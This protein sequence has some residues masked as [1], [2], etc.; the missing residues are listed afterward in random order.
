MNELFDFKPLKEAYD[1]LAPDG[2]EIR[3]LVEFDGGGLAH[4]T[5][6]SKS[7]STPIQHRTVTELWYCLCGM[8]EIWQ[9]LD[10]E[11]QEVK[12]FSKNDS[13]T[14]P[15]GHSFQFRNI[16][17]EPLCIL[18]VTVPKWPGKQEAIKLQGYWK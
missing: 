13:F 8:G 1:Y 11:H 7:M 3:L 15:V 16:G 18:I 10:D 14:I 12:P 2:S 5:L 9:F 6:P 4:C 17:A